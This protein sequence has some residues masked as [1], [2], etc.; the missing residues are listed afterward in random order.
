M[1]FVSESTWCVR[2]GNG[3]WVVEEHVEAKCPWALK[4]F[5]QGTIDKAHKTVLANF[6]EKLKQLE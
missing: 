5:V 2:E 6:I 4:W 3:G 1:G